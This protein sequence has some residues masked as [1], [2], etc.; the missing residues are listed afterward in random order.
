MFVILF[1]KAEL[2]RTVELYR[3]ADPGVIFAEMEKNRAKEKMGYLKGKI[4]GIIITSKYIWTLTKINGF[5]ELSEL[6]SL[7]KIPAAKFL[8]CWT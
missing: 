2:L 6:Q 3:T 8:S 4:N 1:S 7:Q 5:V